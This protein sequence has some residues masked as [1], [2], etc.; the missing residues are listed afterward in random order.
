MPAQAKPGRR[1]PLPSHTTFEQ[2]EQSRGS[3][4]DDSDSDSG[5]EARPRR[6][7]GDARALRRMEMG[8]SEDDEDDDSSPEEQPRR[9]H[10]DVRALRR[11]E[12]GPSEDDED[13]DSDD[14]AAEGAAGSSGDEDSDEAES[15]SDAGT[16]SSDDGGGA[17]LVSRSAQRVLILLRCVAHNRCRGAIG[18]LGSIRNVPQRLWHK[19]ACLL[20]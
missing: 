3:G 6:Q 4:S 11:M 15:A 18:A 10:A 19:W 13:D 16:S 9:R 17:D 20:R 7:H 5:P 8:P 14:D 2:F 1:Q 12:M